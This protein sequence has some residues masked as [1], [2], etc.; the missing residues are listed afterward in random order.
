MIIINNRFLKVQKL[1]IKLIVRT[2]FGF[3]L[4]PVCFLVIAS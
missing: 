2:Q 3:V 1:L 4:F